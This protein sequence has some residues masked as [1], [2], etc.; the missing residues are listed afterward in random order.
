MP[1]SREQQDDQQRRRRF[2]K[3]IDALERLHD[4]LFVG[5]CTLDSDYR[6]A[7]TVRRL[8]RALR[9]QR[10]WLAE[11]EHSLSIHDLTEIL[12][13]KLLSSSIGLTVGEVEF[14]A[15]IAR[16][17]SL[18]SLQ[19]KRYLTGVEA[20]TFL[21]YKAFLTADDL[22][23]VGETAIKIRGEPLTID[24]LEID[25][26]PTPIDRPWKI[27]RSPT[28]IGSPPD[29]AWESAEQQLFD[30]HAG[31]LL[32]LLGKQP[33]RFGADPD[34]RR[35]P[36]PRDAFADEG[37]PLRLSPLHNL[38]Q[39]REH[40]DRSAYHEV[41]VPTAKF[42]K[43]FLAT[44]TEALECA[45]AVTRLSDWIFL[46][47][48]TDESAPKT[49]KHLLTLALTDRLGHF[50]VTDFDSAY[51]QVYESEAHRA[52]VTGWPLHE[53]YKSRLL[54]RKQQAAEKPPE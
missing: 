41:V 32:T 47:H 8:W 28:V 33:S 36:I 27:R 24:S 51:R 49:K 3:V 13:L 30:A 18:T 12:R 4:V 11:E 9:E 22:C 40:A 21:I 52:P 46:Q 16:V 42:A 1:R 17:A 14:M 43:V 45:D 26:E 34:R 2:I 48:P 35:R 53:R 19:P 15:W 25:G 6:R 20:I 31:G 37:S 23:A 29:P 44:A 38:I 54:L 50:R 39:D 7:V 10:F 5:E